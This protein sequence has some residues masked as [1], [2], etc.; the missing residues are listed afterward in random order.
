MRIL[1]ATGNPDKFR[2]IND[3]LALAGH[4]I[5]SLADLGIE[6]PE[7]TGLTLMENARLK[8]EYGFRASG[9][10]T[11]AED[12][13]LCVDALHG[14][15]GVFSSRF[16]GPGA[17][18]RDNRQKLLSLLEGVPF[19]RRRARFT[20]IVCLT[21]NGKDLTF[22]EGWVEGFIIGQ[23]QGEAG[24]GYDPVFLYPPMGRTFAELPPEV[25]NAVSHRAKAF[26]MA[27][28]VLRNAGF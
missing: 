27:R 25:K 3:I 22:L 21:R 5:I 24:F 10:T 11:I 16:A 18:Y 17:T 2:E 14:M 13:G 23:E 4:E 15:P 6:G 20:T 12:T 1:V 9:M 28:E 8:A 7:E 19:S 26:R